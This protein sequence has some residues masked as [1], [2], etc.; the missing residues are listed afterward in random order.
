[1]NSWSVKNNKAYSPR[2]STQWMR[3]REWAF[4]QGHC[5]HSWVERRELGLLSDTRDWAST[6]LAAGVES[7]GVGPPEIE[8]MGAKV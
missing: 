2:G 8:S 3:R 5:E 6:N 1:M 4:S 7:E